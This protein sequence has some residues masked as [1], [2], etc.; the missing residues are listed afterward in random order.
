VR[1]IAWSLAIYA[2]LLG[3]VWCG[4]DRLLFHPTVLAPD[5][6]FA[7]GDDV[8]EVGIEVPG[9]RLSALHLRLPAPRG[10]IVFLHGN[11]GSLDSWFTNTAAWRRANYDLFMI[12][13][14]GFGK[15]TG[16]IESE[17]QLRAD[18][19]AAWDHV[20]P[21]YE[22][23]PRVVY[24][25]SLGT[26]LAAGLAAEVQPDL[27]VLVSP[28]RSMV[29][30]G[31][32]HYPWVPTALLRYPLRTEDDAARIEGPVV[33]FHGEGD[34]LIPISHAEAIAARVPHAELVRLPGAGHDDVHDHPRYREALTAALARLR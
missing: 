31:G 34:T 1:A 5:H 14:R 11:A 28:Y 22:G 32:E 33:I 7:F 25:R 27:T 6:A 20:A 4:Q 24:G 8:H 21:Q 16:A 29:E 30:L 23:K 12:D 19:R 26:A 15:S 9:A 3:A 18:A 17:A 2:T 13:Y 10:V